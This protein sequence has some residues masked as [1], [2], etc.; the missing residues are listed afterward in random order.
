MV[1][2]CKLLSQQRRSN[3]CQSTYTLHLSSI[4]TTISAE[5]DPI[6]GIG[7]ITSRKIIVSPG[8]HDAFS[9]RR[10]LSKFS[11]NSAEQHRCGHVYVSPGGS[12]E[13]CS[14]IWRGAEADKLEVSA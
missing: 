14:L 6:P 11:G 7:S 13:L 10:R 4:N 1:K 8:V 5:E 12:K 3:K 2:P 9:K